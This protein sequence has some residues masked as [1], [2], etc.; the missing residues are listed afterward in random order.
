MHVLMQ[1]HCLVVGFQFSWQNFISTM[2]STLR[3]TLGKK[4][5]RST[6]V[7]VEIINYF[8]VDNC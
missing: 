2:K 5:H 4:N 8:M 1:G 6:K 7:R 3:K